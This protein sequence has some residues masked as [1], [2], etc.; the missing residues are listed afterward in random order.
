MNDDIVID[1]RRQVTREARPV[2]ARV[3]RD[4][5]MALRA[6]EDDV[7]LARIL[8]DAAHGGVA[9]QPS[10]DRFPALAE[11]GG[12]DDVRRKVAAAMCIERNVGGSTGGV[13]RE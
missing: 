1:G 9:S 5:E 8:R 6:G 11:V 10:A 12:S 3:E 13:R 7:R 4:E 2:H